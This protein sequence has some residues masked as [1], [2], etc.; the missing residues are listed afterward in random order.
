MDSKITSAK[1]REIIRIP[2]KYADNWLK[3]PC[4]YFCWGLDAGNYFDFL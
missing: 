2:K 4:R 1:F 3:W